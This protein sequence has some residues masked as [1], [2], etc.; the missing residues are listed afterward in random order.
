[1]LRE[2]PRRP[3]PST[4]RWGSSHGDAVSRVLG[5]GRRV[6]R[7]AGTGQRPAG[8]VACFGTTHGAHHCPSPTVAAWGGFAATCPV[9][10]DT[11]AGRREDQG[12]PSACTPHHTHTQPPMLRT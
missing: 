12:H 3:Q 10:D 5:C 1:M 4:F 7:R 6:V 11:V 8:G 2:T 9:T